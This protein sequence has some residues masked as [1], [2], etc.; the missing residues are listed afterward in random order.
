M[1]QNTSRSLVRSPVS[2]F[3]SGFKFK[4]NFLPSDNFL[5]F[6]DIMGII[7]QCPVFPRNN[8]WTPTVRQSSPAKRITSVYKWL[9]QV[10]SAFL[11]APAYRSPAVNIHTARTYL[12]GFQILFGLLEKKKHKTFFFS[13]SKIMSLS[14]K[15]LFT[16]EDWE[17]PMCLCKKTKSLTH[18]RGQTDLVR[19]IPRQ[20]LTGWVL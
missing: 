4:R 3:P 16:K 13:S 6:T 17:L 9:L 19:V 10:T 11:S 14:K 12:M 5:P 7:Q 2:E 20:L 8:T 1:C 15:S 18:Y